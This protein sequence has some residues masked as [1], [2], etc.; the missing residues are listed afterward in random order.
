MFSLF[1]IM[2]VNKD[3]FSSKGLVLTLIFSMLGILETMY[4][5]SSIIF[6]FNDIMTD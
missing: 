3:S 5:F 1:G 4:L 6:D 2:A